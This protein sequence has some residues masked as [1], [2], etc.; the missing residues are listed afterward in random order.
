MIRVEGDRLLSVTIGTIS[1]SA[2][3]TSM[4]PR[5]LQHIASLKMMP[6]PIVA[7]AQIIRTGSWRATR[8]GTSQVLAV[9]QA[10][11][12][13]VHHFLTLLGTQAGRASQGS[14]SPSSGPQTTFA[15]SMYLYMLDAYPHVPKLCSELFFYSSTA[16]LCLVILLLPL[17]YLS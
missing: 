7:S 10:P 16:K 13:D 14:H 12:Q 3:I 11:A 6:F 8:I 1:R 15:P 17:Q 9:L 4:L 5:M 2:M